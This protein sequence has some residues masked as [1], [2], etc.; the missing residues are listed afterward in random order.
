[1]KKRTLC[2]AKW[3]G[4]P[5]MSCQLRKEKSCSACKV[6]LLK[7]EKVYR[8]ILDGCVGGVQRYDRLCAI[9]MEAKG[10]EKKYLDGKP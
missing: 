9:C 3:R 2:L 1:M 5:M 7:G 4:M 6:I 10:T 8:P